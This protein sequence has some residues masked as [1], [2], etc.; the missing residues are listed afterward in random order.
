VAVLD[1]RLVTKS[2]G[3]F[4]RSSLPPLWGTGDKKTILA[5]LGRLSAA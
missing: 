2:Y 4:L 1:S 5:A 3:G